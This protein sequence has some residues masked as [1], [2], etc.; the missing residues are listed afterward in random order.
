MGKSYLPQ[1]YCPITVGGGS[2]AFIDQW[3]EPI[4]ELKEM[5]QQYHEFMENT[6]FKKCIHGIYY[7]AIIYVINMMY[8][9]ANIEKV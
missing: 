1:Y 4:E 3:D 5:V 6:I 8:L 9:H 2:E 7:T